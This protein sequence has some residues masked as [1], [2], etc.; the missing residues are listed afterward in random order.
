MKYANNNI[1][2]ILIFLISTN[3][4]SQNISEQITIKFDYSNYKNHIYTLGSDLFEGRGTGTKGG[5]LA[6][7]YIK[8]KFKEI[9]LSTIPNSNAYFQEVPL[10]GSIALDKSKLVI[11]TKKDTFF[12]K[13]REDYL[14]INTGEQ[15]IIPYPIEITF[16]GYGI[17]A[18]EFDHFDYGEN[19]IT[20]KISIIFSGEPESNDFDYFNGDQPTIYSYNDVK[21]RIALSRGAAGTIIIPQIQVDS[22]NEW[23]KLINEY[24]FEDVNLLY[25]ASKNFSIILNPKIAKEIFNISQLT[26][27]AEITKNFN[28]SNFKLMFEG[29]FQERDF[30][31]HNVIGILN[32][33]GIKTEDAIIISAH[34]DH[35]G[36]GAKV[37]GDSIYNG[38][39]DNAMGISALIEI[40]KILKANERFLNRSIIFIAVTGEEKGLLGSTYYTDH[41]IIPLYKTISNLNIDGIAYLDEF[42]SVIGIG[43]E[44]SDLD[45][46]F[47]T[48]ANLL[49]L[50][51]SEIPPEFYNTEAFNRSDQIAFAKAGIPSI[52]VLDGIDYKNISREDAL[53]KIFYYNQNIYHTPFDDLTTKIDSDAVQKHIKFL[54]YLIFQIANSTNEIKWKPNS[55]YN[56]MRLQTKAEKR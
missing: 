31:A 20:G 43:S 56:F 29:N 3:T 49:D 36:I 11:Y 15:T 38:V 24:S 5:E 17:I 30:I 50:K 25:S 9:N 18:P 32:P 51:I 1:V 14:L 47:E 19:D 45:L 23:H 41:P 26:S 35:L 13:H 4:F 22:F 27:F 48:T 42:N 39:L 53:R 37:N 55:P 52:L 28:K 7:N 54:T 2:L 6:A 34:Y 44:L 33:N 10:H 40:A 21:N 8:E 16:S 12:L 46:L